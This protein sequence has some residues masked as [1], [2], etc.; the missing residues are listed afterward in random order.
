MNPLLKLGPSD[1]ESGQYLGK[2]QTAIK[3]WGE[4]Y[5]V[6][7][8]DGGVR[9]APSL[10]VV[11][12][13][14][15][16]IIAV[17]QA[18]VA[19]Q[20]R[21]Y[22]AS[23]RFIWMWADGLLTQLGTFAV[24]ST[25]V[26]LETWGS[27]LVA[28]NGQGPIKVWKNGGSMVDLGGTPPGATRILKR[29]FER[30]FAAGTITGDNVLEWSATSDIEDWVPSA[31]NSAGN[32]FMRDLDS[33]I[34][35]VEELSDG[36]AVYS[37]N[38]IALG[39]FIGSPFVVGFTDTVPASGARS[40]HS[41]I[42]Y[43][44]LNFVM[45]NNGLYTTDGR[46]ISSVGDD[47]IK[48]WLQDEQPTNVVG[49]LDERR[50]CI[51]WA[52]SNYLGEYKGLAL[53]HKKGV[54]CKIMSKITAAAPRVVFEEPIVASGTD[55]GFWSFGGASQEFS[56]KT[57]VSDF[58]SSTRRK[59][60]SGIRLG[61]KS[62]GTV[63]L[64]IGEANSNEGP[65]NWFYDAPATELQYMMRDIAYGV[66]ELYGTGKFQL[67]EMEIFGNPGALMT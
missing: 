64:R 7:F 4:G 37:Q 32:K 52:F 9:S 54:F 1:L 65:I 47:E 61:I 59:V 3:L 58:G 57:R 21:I 43:S 60:L 48:T 44:N 11:T 51:V 41:V 13:V 26:D 56:I 31:A 46:S 35:A 27:W 50:N 12:S 18:Y 19:G 2:N 17:A 67:S 40:K 39:K 16:D 29:K 34:I 22:A 20:K 10:D 33:Q 42:P 25:D 8:Q 55:L 14:A 5:N 15:D 63:N 24:E 45:G 36:I 53:Q 6:L 23:K 62:T 38:S 30:I 28:T 66:I 49:F